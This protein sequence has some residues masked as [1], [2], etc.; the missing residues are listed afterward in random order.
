LSAVI[1]RERVLGVLLV[2]ISACGFG[3]G[4]LFAK[5]IYAAG[6]DWMILLAWRFLFAAALSWAWL[7]A[8]PSHRQ[9]LGRISRRRLLVLVLLGL[10]YLGNSGTYFA[11]LET[12]PASLAALIVYLYPALVAVM[13][14]RFARRL[15]GRRAWGAL[16]LATLG[17]VLAVGG[18][19]PGTAPPIEGLLLVLVSPLF[20]AV[21]II[22][23]ARLGGERAG[24][25]PTGS[26]ERASVPPH[27]SET[28][29]QPEQTDSAPAAAIMLTTTAV[30]WWVAAVLTGRPVAPDQI[31]TDAW[32][33]LLGV[34]V[35]ATAVAL[36]AF[37]AG[38]RRIGAAQASL[39]ST[40]E[41]V[42]TIILATVLFGE[43]LGTVQVIGGIMVITGVV[44]AQV[45]ELQSDRPSEH[46]PADVVT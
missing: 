32:L 33:P 8:W 4:P 14:I 24:V 41:P 12:V 34:G 46:T 1:G 28:I 22:L 3:S 44:I 30:A 18:I 39:V 13:S 35:V 36:Q 27:D 42:Y 9:A 21:W 25:A 40:V 11:G 29:T 6:V 45:G 17:V 20:Y 26:H 5:P 31:P 2:V 38:T 23:S 15:E 10:L 16:G 19:D 37:Y 7:F 43:M